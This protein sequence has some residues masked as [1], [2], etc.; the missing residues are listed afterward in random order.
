MIG[1]ND[2]LN[3]VPLVKIQNNYTKILKSFSSTQK[4]YILSLLPVIDVKQTKAINRDIKTMNN[5]LKNEVKKYDFNFI[6]LYP[7]F[8]DKNR[9]GLSDAYTTDGIHLTSKAYKVWEKVLKE[10]LKQ[11]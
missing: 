1:V 6:N 10:K 2:I 11:H 9:Q 4:I 7:D 8:L 5:W 3:Q